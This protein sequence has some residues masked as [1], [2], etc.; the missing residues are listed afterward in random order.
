MP[1]DGISAK[2]LAIELNTQLKDA[3]I[4]RI[5][6]PDRTDI[7]LLLRAGRENLRLVLS[8]NPAAPRIHLTNEAREN[9]SEPPMFCMLLRKHLLG[10]RVLSVETPGYERIF[11]LRLATQNELGDTLEK[12]LVVEIMGR[13]SNIILL[14]QD[15]RIHDAI[16]HIDQSI[17]RL[18]EIMP[19]RTYVEPHNQT[20]PAPDQV[21]Q[22]IRDG[23]PFIA[24]E[25]SSKT[26]DKALLESVQGF[27]PQ[28][29][30]A[31]VQLAGLDPRTR[32]NQLT[33][34]EQATLT[35]QLQHLLETILGHQFNPSTF[36][37]DAKDTIP[38]DFHAL[39]LP[40]LAHPRPETSLSAAMDRFY[41]E[42]NRQNRLAQQKQSLQKRVETELDHAARK[43]Q[44]HQ[45]ELTE[46]EKRDFYRI[47]GELLAAQQYLIQD[48][49]AFVDVQNYYDPDLAP[50][51]IDLLP[52]L[53]PSQ[54]V[55]RYFKLYQ[56]A[57]GKFETNTR[58]VQ[59]DLADLEW[60]G[61][62]KSAVQKASDESDIQA[63]REEIAATG[64]S[65]AERRQKSQD[66]DGASSQD[67]KTKNPSSQLRDFAPGKPGSKARR[68]AKGKQSSGSKG[69]AKAAV[70][71]PPPL[72]PRSYLSS[73][74]FLI[75][76]GRN[77]LQNDRLTLRTAQK[78][79]LWFHAQKIPGTHVIIRCGK[80]PVPERTLEEAAQIAA[81]FSQAAAS[82]QQGSTPASEAHKIAVDYCPVS[83]V[84]KIAGAK[85]GLVQYDRYQTLLVR[86][87][88]PAEWA[89]QPSADGEQEPFM[90]DVP[91]EATE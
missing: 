63:I 6:Q 28:L 77:N 42:R 76:A 83:Q 9:P 53:S 30:Q 87:R 23:I 78:D 55:Q 68:H 61:S 49:L 11:V 46:G 35:L 12:K 43:L 50:I 21:L 59:E 84:K 81:W 31:V 56:K 74:G 14:N 36:Y 2:C 48:G 66:P 40:N 3:R 8:A 20:K 17:S 72:P 15:N 33:P 73:D 27:S 16:L 10:A 47:C 29:C 26:V 25:A 75:Q 37:L 13:H 45:I 70:K 22:T 5:Y 39:A 90:A 19:A 60:L 79:D 18:R 44:L 32:Y 80:R 58:L 88:D 1:L 54:N 38:F 69:K 34:S 82:L 62:L 64:L 91:D 4:D 85:P 65:S 67:R 41:L 7:L 57:R 86:P 51:R 71:N 24:P 89:R 52:A